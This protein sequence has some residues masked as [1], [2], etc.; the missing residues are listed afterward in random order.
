MTS[1]TITMKSLVRH[2]AHEWDHTLCTDS[3]AFNL[4]PHMKRISKS[5]LKGSRLLHEKELGQSHM[6]LTALAQVAEMAATHTES[7]VL[8]QRHGN[9][10]QLET[11][12]T[13]GFKLIRRN[14]ALNRI[15]HVAQNQSTKKTLSIP[16]PKHQD[17][18]STEG[19]HPPSPTK[20]GHTMLKNTHHFV[21]FSST[22]G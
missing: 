20:N 4:Q 15:E 7:R 3:L 21:L 18:D 22:T 1:K 14:A 9:K 8:E 12:H 5:A 13:A 6:R 2:N 19:S 10:R 16:S 17:A 11:P